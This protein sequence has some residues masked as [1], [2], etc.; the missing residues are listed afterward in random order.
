MN[1]S[2]TIAKNTSSQSHE[3][4]EAAKSLNTQRM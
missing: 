4:Q 3:E 1:Q 2:A